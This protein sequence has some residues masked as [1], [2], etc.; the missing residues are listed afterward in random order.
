MAL[1]DSLSQLAKKPTR[2]KIALLFFVLLVFGFIYYQFRYS[3]LADTKDSLESK[4]DSLTAQQRKLDGD[5]D[6]LRE[7]SAKND[8]LQQTIRDNLKALPFEAELPAFLDHLQRKAGDAGVTIRKWENLPEEPIDDTYIRVPVKVDVHGSFYQI[9]HYFFLLG[10][11]PQDPLA[12]DENGEEKKERIHERIVSIENVELD[13]AAFDEG[14]LKIEASFIAATFRQPAPA[15]TTPKPNAQPGAKTP[16]RPGAPPAN[17]AGRA[18]AGNTGGN[19]GG[20]RTS[21]RR[22]E[23]ARTPV[24]RRRRVASGHAAL[25]P[26]GGAP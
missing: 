14:E 9:M 1:S 2:F 16:A 5:L 17:P 18:P 24:R 25:A 6:K 20:A 26:S 7:L 10:P 3:E 19:R 13:K 22:R 21:K 12:R 8:E 11:K 4:K 23:R 15:A